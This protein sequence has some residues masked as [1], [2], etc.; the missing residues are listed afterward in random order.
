MTQHLTSLLGPRARL[1][2]AIAFGAFLIHAGTALL[3]IGSFFPTPQAYDFSSYYAGAWSLRLDASPYA[4]TDTFLGFLQAEQAVAAPPPAHN[5]TPLWAWLMQ[6]W[7]LLRFPAAATLWTLALLALSV[8]G[9]VRLAEIAGIGQRRHIGWTL[10]LTLTFGPL[11]LNLTLG[12]NGILLLVS[13]L[14]SAAALRVRQTGP[15]L[16]AIL[17]WVAAVG[18]KIYPALWVGSLFFARRWR[19]F[20]AALLACGVAF[21]TIWLLEPAVSREYWLA[22]LPRQARDF[23]TGVSIDDQALAAYLIR[24]GASSQ[25]GFADISA[26]GIAQVT[27]RMPWEIPATTMRIVAYAVLAL[28]GGALAWIWWRSAAQQPA[29]ALFSAA[30]YSLLVFPH[31]DRYNHV[32]ALPALA[33]LWACGRRCRVIAIMAYALFALSR[34]NQIW[35]RLP[36][37][38]GPIATGFGLIAVLLLLAAMAYRLWRLK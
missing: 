3:R 24:L 34:L 21:G 10:P 18:A 1:W 17:L 16:I 36:A 38:L 29:G 2:A 37:P 32:V 7:T 23:A 28:I 31:M 8:Y 6:P 14:L 20:A 13:L 19:A 9:H 30:L 25:Y 5:S 33:W 4:W 26:R 22:F 35:T 15:R 27:W 12:Q 11:F